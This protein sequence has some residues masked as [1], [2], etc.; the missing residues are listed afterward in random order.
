MNRL[1]DNLMEEHPEEYEAMIE[2]SNKEIEQAMDNHWNLKV[3][4]EGM[5]ASIYALLRVM[6][7][8]SPDYEEFKKLC[9]RMNE[10]I[11]QHNRMMEML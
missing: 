3:A 7:K 1:A 9:L 5:R 4:K 6:D 8:G 11:R 2:Q 10:E